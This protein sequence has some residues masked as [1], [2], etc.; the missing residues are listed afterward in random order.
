VFELEREQQRLLFGGVIRFAQ[1][2]EKKYGQL[3]EDITNEISGWTDD[4]TSGTE[5]RVK[6]TA[7]L[8]N[9]KIA[10]AGHSVAG[11]VSK[12]EHFVVGSV[13]KAEQSVVVG[14][15]K[16]QNYV[17]YGLNKADRAVNSAL[18]GTVG[19]VSRVLWFW[20]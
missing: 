12:A 14:I 2:A 17:N 13:G 19:R 4:V 20:K 7:V 16:A 11:A 18:N 3:R 9:G 6:Q 5:S 15:G 1:A 8:V 10:L